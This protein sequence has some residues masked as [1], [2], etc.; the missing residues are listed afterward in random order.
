MWTGS[1]KNLLDV[2][3][4][5]ESPL[6][7]NA[8]AVTRYKF[9]V[10][11]QQ[12]RI[13][14]QE[15]VRYHLKRILILKSRILIN[16]I[17]L[18]IYVVWWQCSVLRLLAHLPTVPWEIESPCSLNLYYKCT[19]THLLVTMWMPLKK[20]DP[21]LLECEPGTNPLGKAKSLPSSLHL[22]H[23]PILVIKIWG[24]K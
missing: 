22:P 18:L 15:L 16:L 2:T 13:S 17:W 11:W 12:N 14:V 24:E 5:K 6:L 20:K 1:S 19:E 4:G 3:F 10:Q 23:S 8:Y 7:L 9:T 21:S